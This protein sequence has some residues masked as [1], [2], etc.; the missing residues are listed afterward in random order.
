M[1]AASIP[2]IYDPRWHPPVR[3]SV[4]PKLQIIGERIFFAGFIGIA[5]AYAGKLVTLPDAR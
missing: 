3:L 1:L 4:N 2:I 5:V